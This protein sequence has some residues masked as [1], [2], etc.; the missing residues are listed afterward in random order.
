MSA[1]SLFVFL[2]IASVAKQ[3]SD[4]QA[5]TGLLRRFAA[6][7]DGID[8]FRPLSAKNATFQ[9]TLRQIARATFLNSAFG[10]A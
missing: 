10:V 6:R 4:N 2:V 1:F 5:K 9:I 7:N 8:C 3:S